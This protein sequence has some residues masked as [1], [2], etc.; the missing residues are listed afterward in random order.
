MGQANRRAGSVQTLGRIHL[1]D[2]QTGCL[3]CGERFGARRQDQTWLGDWVNYGE[4]AYVV[5]I[6]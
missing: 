1:R 2:I 4:G 5:F 6:D 3:G